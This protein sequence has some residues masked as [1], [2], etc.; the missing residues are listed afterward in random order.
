MLLFRFAFKMT[1]RRPGGGD[2]GVHFPYSESPTTQP[3]KLAKECNL[4]SIDD[5]AEPPFDLKRF[6]LNIR[7]EAAEGAGVLDGLLG[8]QVQLAIA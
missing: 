8:G 5:V 2:G 3:T 1:P 6:L 4:V 7:R